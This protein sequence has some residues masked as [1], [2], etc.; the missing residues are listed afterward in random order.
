MARPVSSGDVF[1]DLGAEEDRLEDLLNDLGHD[2]WTAESGAPGWSVADVVLHLAVSEE[3]AT[4]TLAAGAGSEAANEV[5]VDD[6]MDAMVRQQRADPA[7]SF[8]RWRS[9]RRAAL[10]ALRSADPAV[11]VSWAAT[12]L[13]PATLATTRIAEH[14]AHGLDITAPLGVSWEDTPRLRHVAWLAHRTLPYSFTL[15]GHQ[16]RPVRVELVG[17]DGNQWDFGPADAPSL[18]TGPAGDFCRVAAQRLGPEQ[19]RLACS[20]PHGE[21]ALSVVRTYAA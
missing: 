15:A 14:W 13:R 8:E 7:A 11:A 10:S 16:P 3:L 9:A 18:I 2:Q 4:L 20:G 12:P 19:S 17:P 1:D 5:P 21:E 6:A